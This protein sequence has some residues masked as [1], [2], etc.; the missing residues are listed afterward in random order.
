M[1]SIILL[2]TNFINNNN[3]INSDPNL[4]KNTDF[5]GKTCVE[6]LNT[7]STTCFELALYFARHSRTLMGTQIL[8]ISASQGVFG[9][10]KFR[11]RNSASKFRSDFKKSVFS[12]R[13]RFATPRFWGFGFPSRSLNTLQSIKRVQS[14]LWKLCYGKRDFFSGC[15]NGYLRFNTL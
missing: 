2:T 4:A 15:W 9:R 8:K 5:W 11:L 3:W 7:V 12:R 6:R 1:S 14:V 10:K 13:L